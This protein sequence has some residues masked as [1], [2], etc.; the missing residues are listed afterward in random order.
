M[1]ISGKS[2]VENDTVDASVVR[3]TDV[4]IIDEFSMIACDCAHH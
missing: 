2:S 4:L 1:D 3:Q